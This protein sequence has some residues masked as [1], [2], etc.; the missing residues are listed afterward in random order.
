M[1]TIPRISATPWWSP[2]T[3][4]LI[5]HKL[6]SVKMHARTP[7]NTLCHTSVLRDRGEISSITS[8]L[9]ECRTL[10]GEPERVQLSNVHEAVTCACVPTWSRCMCMTGSAC[11]QNVTE[12]KAQLKDTDHTKN[13]PVHFTATANQVSRSSLV[14]RSRRALCLRCHHRRA[15]FS[16]TADARSVS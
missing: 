10:W 8:K 14:G 9:D 7:D 12:S 4:D 15:T 11:H 16:F 13:T 1:V 3:T 5:P 2:V 6:V